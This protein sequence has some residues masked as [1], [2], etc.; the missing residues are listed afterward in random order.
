MRTFQGSSV[1][2]KDPE[3]QRAY[4]REHYRKR[5]DKRVRMQAGGVRFS[6]GYAPTKEDAQRILRQMKE[7]FHAPES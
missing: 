1:S 5:S 2:Y 4:Q 6:L 7:A 3:K